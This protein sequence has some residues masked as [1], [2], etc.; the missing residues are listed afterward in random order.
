MAGDGRVPRRRIS[1][2]RRH[3]RASK[4]SGCGGLNGDLVLKPGNRS[5]G[6]WV[7]VRGHRIRLQG[8][9]RVDTN[10]NVYVPDSEDEEPGM[11]VEV[12]GVKV[13]DLEGAAV[14]GDGFDVAA[15]GG[16][17]DGVK[18]PA[19]AASGDEMHPKVVARLNMVLAHIDPAFHD[20]FV[21]MLKVLVPAF[22]DP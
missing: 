8:R 11:E 16:E 5:C 9:M 21:D 13:A 19:D 15:E 12:G 2:V 14:V 18:V 1:W 6:E 10:G 17:A 22:F 4:L 20:I 7:C 3:R